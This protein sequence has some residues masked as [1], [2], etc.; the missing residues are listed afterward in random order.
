[1]LNNESCIRIFFWEGGWWVAVCATE[2]AYDRGKQKLIN[3]TSKSIS[4]KKCSSVFIFNLSFEFQE[5]PCLKI[6]V[7]N[8]NKR[9]PD[10]CWFF[11]F[12]GMTKKIRTSLKLVFSKMWQANSW[13]LSYQYR[14]RD[15]HCTLDWHSVEVELVTGVND[16]VAFSGKSCGDGD[17]LEPL[18]GALHSSFARSSIRLCCCLHCTRKTF[19]L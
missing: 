6:G 18:K 13:R 5:F 12:F 1:M 8:W 16:T 19:T 11:I 3:I 10:A 17:G 7:N 2:V 14:V 4:L 9:G 15:S